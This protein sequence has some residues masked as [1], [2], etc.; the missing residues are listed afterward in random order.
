MPSIGRVS[1]KRKKVSVRYVYI[2]GKP[3]VCN[4]FFFSS[5]HS[6]FRHMYANQISFS[7][8]FFFLFLSGGALVI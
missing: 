4:F 8:N 2:I 5:S 3:S 7:A 1:T 6:E